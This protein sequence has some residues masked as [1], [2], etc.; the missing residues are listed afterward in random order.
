MAID[1]GTDTLGRTV[2]DL[3]MVTLDATIRDVATEN[4]SWLVRRNVTYQEVEY[5]HGARAARLTALSD[6]LLAQMRYWRPHLVASESPF[7]GRRANAYEALVEA[8]VML[9]QTYAQYDQHRAIELVTPPEAKVAV[10]VRSKDWKKKEAT[11][12]AI[13]RLLAAPAIHQLHYHAQ[14]PYET[15]DEHSIDAISVGYC[16]VNEA[17]QYLRHR[18]A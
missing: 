17:R 12:E 16:K 13:A 18:G 1:P 7:M 11:Q 15:L 3:D 14:V 8:M 6:T 5:W 2:I 4:A 9:R 10:G